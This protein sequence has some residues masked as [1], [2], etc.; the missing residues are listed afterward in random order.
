MTPINNYYFSPDLHGGH[1]KLDFRHPAN[2]EHG[3]GVQ[4][5]RLAWNV[6]GTVLGLS[7]DDG[8]IC[9]YGHIKMWS[10][11]SIPI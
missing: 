5:W 6:T 7:D 8:C 11:D 1:T 9:P 2:L 4:V 3:G 10:H